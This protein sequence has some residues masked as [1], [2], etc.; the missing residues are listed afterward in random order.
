MQQ[1][2]DPAWRKSSRSV[3]GSNNCVEVRRATGFVALRDSKDPDGPVLLFDRA[4]W[5][6]FVEAVKEGEFDL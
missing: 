6:S 3:S 1:H 5:A 2:V 4:S